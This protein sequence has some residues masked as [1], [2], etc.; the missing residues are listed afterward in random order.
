MLFRSGQRDPRL[1]QVGSLL[2]KTYKGKKLHVKV[3]E[4]GFEYDGKRYRSL[5]GIARAVTGATWN[6]FLFFGLTPRPKTEE[7]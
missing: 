4:E 3:T 2:T 5:S 6:G 7:E 1:P